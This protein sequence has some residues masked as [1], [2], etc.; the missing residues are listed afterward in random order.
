M[1]KDMII[2]VFQII[3]S[4]FKNLD[5]LVKSYQ[6]TWNRNLP[7]KLS[8]VCFKPIYEKSGPKDSTEWN[9]PAKGND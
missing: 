9:I 8:T 4:R 2:V 5:E 3:R 7:T 6:K 1:K